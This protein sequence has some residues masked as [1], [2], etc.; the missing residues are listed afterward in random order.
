MFVFIFRQINVYYNRDADIIYGKVQSEK[1]SRKRK[2][3][4]STTNTSIISGTSITGLSEGSSMRELNKNKVIFIKFIN[5]GKF[6]SYFTQ[7]TF[8]QRLLIAADYDRYL[9]SQNSSDGDGL[10]TF[11]QNHSTYSGQSSS[12]KSSENEG[13]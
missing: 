13:K 9:Q 8:F 1:T 10:S 7:T 12:V 11:S 2:R 5:K 3:S 4:R 6:I